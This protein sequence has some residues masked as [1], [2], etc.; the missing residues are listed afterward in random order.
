MRRG[1][2]FANGFDNLL[3]KYRYALFDAR[4]AGTIICMKKLLFCFCAV[5][6]ALNAGGLCAH[7]AETENAAQPPASALLAHAQNV[8]ESGAGYIYGA[9]GQTSTADFRH[10]RMQLYPEHEQLIRRWGE[11]WD[12]LPVYDCIGLLKAFAREREVASIRV[13]V[14]TTGAWETWVSDWGVLEGAA[15]TPGMVLFRIEGSRMLVKH[16][17]VY[18]GS[19]RVI[20]ARGTRW[21]VVE[22][23]LPNVFTHWAQLHWITYDLP[24]ETVQIGRAH[25]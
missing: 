17:G 1:V 10:G 20:H 8:L 11:A 23:E 16:V 7:A 21:G 25:V 24:P 22:D 14:N 18:M 15:L 5:W 19:G 3:K 9:S 13:D 2:P 12:G 4:E 6:I